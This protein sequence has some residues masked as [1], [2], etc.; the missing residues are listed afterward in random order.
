VR[1]FLVQRL[2]ARAQAVRPVLQAAIA[3]RD[4]NKINQ[5]LEKAHHIQM[6]GVVIYE[7]HQCERIKFIAVEVI[8]LK[9]V[10]KSKWWCSGCRLQR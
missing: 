3:S 4:L 2:V 5:A 1:R 10:F 9:G 7:V 8:R 6:Y